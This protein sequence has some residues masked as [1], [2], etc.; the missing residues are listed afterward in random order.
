MMNFPERKLRVGGYIIF[1]SI[2][3]I[4]FMLEMFFSWQ[5]EYML[6]KVL[7]LTFTHTLLIWEPTRFFIL[8]LR[9]K[10]PGLSV[11]KK[12]LAIAVAVLTPYAGLLGFL[13]IFIEDYSN[14]WGVPVA[15]FSTYSYTIGISLL[16]ILLE[17]AIYE[18]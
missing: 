3:F 11:A 2:F 5:D 14:Y 13:R 15:N 16:F 12:R 1:T 10:Y 18:S 17:L 7:L 8:S 6:A 4:F 9:K